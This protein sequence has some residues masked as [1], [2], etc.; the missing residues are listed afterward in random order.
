MAVTKLDDIE[1]HSDT[2]KHPPK[3]GVYGVKQSAPDMDMA[4]WGEVDLAA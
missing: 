2:S 3:L 1:M 4:F